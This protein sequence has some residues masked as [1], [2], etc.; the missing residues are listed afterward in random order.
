M[1][2]I[3][4]E[5]RNIELMAR[6]HMVLDEIN[7]ELE[8]LDAYELRTCTMSEWHNRKDW[9]LRKFQEREE[10][11]YDH[12]FEKETVHLRAHLD[13]LMRSR[14]AY[15]RAKNAFERSEEFRKGSSTTEAE[16]NKTL[17]L[18]DGFVKIKDFKL[19]ESYKAKK[20]R[21]K[22]EAEQAKMK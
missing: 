1:I 11:I 19:P 21:R 14:F 10:D 2:V 17:S 8:V 16:W 4:N 6:H 15:R 3:A 12:S 20:L 5:W 7:M 9:Y 13:E 18:P 22:E